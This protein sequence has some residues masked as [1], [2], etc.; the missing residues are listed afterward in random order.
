MRTAPKMIVD[1]GY[2]RYPQARIFQRVFDTLGLG[3]ARLD[4]KQAHDRGEA[5]LD[6]V[7]HLARQ[8]RLVLE[9][10]LKSGVSLLAFDCDP[11][12]PG[13]SGK[14]IG[15]ALIELTGIG[16][17]TSSTPK[18]ALPSPPFSISTLMARLTP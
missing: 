15:V 2:G 12:Q 5:V 6:A 4:P 16:A 17:A 7:A 13:E 3:T 18:K 8:Q 1:L 11:K 14:K 10:L 9:C